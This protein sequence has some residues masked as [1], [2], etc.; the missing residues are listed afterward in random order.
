MQLNATDT[1]TYLT[2]W[3]EFLGTMMEANYKSDGIRISPEV[4][5]KRAYFKKFW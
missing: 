2:I 5:A 4:S 1:D 3:L